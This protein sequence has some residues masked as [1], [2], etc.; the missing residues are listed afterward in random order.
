M[1]KNG[2]TEDGREEISVFLYSIT[3]ISY[4]ILNEFDESK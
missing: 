4:E 3:F 1:H 2:E